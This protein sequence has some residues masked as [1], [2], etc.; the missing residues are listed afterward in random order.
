MPR[1]RRLGFISAFL[2]VTVPV[3]TGACQPAPPPPQAQAEPYAPT[4]TIKDLMLSIIDPAADAVWLSVTT[5]QDEKGIT[6]KAPTNDEEWRAVRSGA[7]Q[8]AEAANLLMMPGRRMARPGE[9]SETP[10]VELEPEEMDALVAKDRGGWVTRATAPARGRRRRAQGGRREG[11]AEGVRDRRADR[12]GVRGVPLPVLVPEA[13]R[14]HPSPIS[15]R[16]RYPRT[17]PR[18]RPGRS[19]PGRKECSWAC[20]SGLGAVAWPCCLPL[21]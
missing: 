19:S 14:F 11:L 21:A 13:R 6:D 4:A 15:P 3:L 9:K 8:L 16:R 2:L 7:I 12:A 17:R 10:G 5:V 18:R 1:F 20:I